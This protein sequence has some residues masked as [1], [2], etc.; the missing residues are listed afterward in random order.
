MF[1][2]FTHTSFFRAVAVAV[3]VAFVSLIPA[4]S[5]YAQ[6]L[7]Q[8][9]EPGQMV[10]TTG[11]FEPAL[12]AGLRVDMKDPFKFYFVMDKGEQVMAPDVESQEYQKLIKYFLASLTIAND[13]MWVN[14][15]PHEANRIIPDNFA[16]TSMGR[17]LLAQDYLLKQ[18]TASLIYP[19]DK[20]GRDF[21][22]KVYAKVYERY[23]T[24]EIPLDTFNK[25]WITADK[26]DIYQKNDTAL[27]LNSHLKVMLEQDFMA[28]EQNKEQ[29]GNVQ[30]SDIPE[31]NAARK[32][33]A[34]IVREII[35]PVIE[36]EVNDGE[37]FAQV[38]QVYSAMIMASWFKKTL[39][40]SLLGQIYTDKNKVSG[41][42]V[43]DP[44]AKEKIYQKY[45]E[46]YKAGV[47]N[48][49]KEEVD[50][51]THEMLP[52]KYF[53]GGLN[54]G[55]AANPD[56][57]TNFAQATEKM[58]Q[59]GGLKNVARKALLTVAL[60]AMG[61]MGSMGFTVQ[62]QAQTQPAVA[63]VVQIADTTSAVSKL[64]EGL[65]KLGV[66]VK[67]LTERKANVNRGI[68][69]TLQQ[70]IDALNS[71]IRDMEA[72]LQGL[73]PGSVS[74]EELQLAQKSYQK[75]IQAL[76]D[77]VARLENGSKGMA[78]GVKI[79]YDVQIN[80]TKGKIERLQ[81]LLKMLETPSVPTNVVE[82]SGDKVGPVA[83]N[84]V[85][86]PVVLDAE[87]LQA[88]EAVKKLGNEITEDMQ[89][90]NG[91]GAVTEG[92]KAA[93]K[94]LEQKPVL[95][96]AA[97]AEIAGLK[98]QVEER[99][100]TIQTLQNDRNSLN[101]ANADL[102]KKQADAEKSV[103]AVVQ[104]ESNL[105]HNIGLL[106]GG[107]F[108]GL[109]ASAGILKLDSVLEKRKKDLARAKA[110]EIKA[111]AALEEA[112]KNIQ[113]DKEALKKQELDVNNSVK[114]LE[115]EVVQAGV[116]SKVN[117]EIAALQEKI[118]A[119][120]KEV[121][122]AVAK[123]KRLNEEIAALGQM[124]GPER[125]LLDQVKRIEGLMKSKEGDLQ[126]KLNAVKSGI[127]QLKAV[128]EVQRTA[129]K[130]RELNASTI[131]K[132]DLPKARAA[133]AR[134]DQEMANLTAIEDLLGKDPLGNFLA[135]QELL[136]EV[137]LAVNNA[138]AMRKLLAEL[139]IAQG[140]RKQA[141]RAL[142]DASDQ[143]RRLKKMAATPGAVQQ[144]QDIT[145]QERN[146]RLGI[147]NDWLAKNE[148]V[149]TGD[150]MRLVGGMY[151]GVGEVYGPDSTIKSE[152]LR[153]KF[154]T[155]SREKQVAVLTELVNKI[156]GNDIFDAKEKADRVALLQKWLDD[157]PLQPAVEAPAKATAAPTAPATEKPSAIKQDQ[158][159]PV[160]I[161][162]ADRNAAEWAVFEGWDSVEKKL[163]GIV[164]SYGKYV[165]QFKTWPLVK[166]IAAI[167]ASI[168]E[169]ENEKNLTGEDEKDRLLRIERMNDWLAFVSAPAKQGEEAA[170]EVSED[171]VTTAGLALM[172][173]RYDQENNKLLSPAP[174]D[175]EYGKRVVLFNSWS[176]QKQ[177]AAVKKALDGFI[178]GGVL[179]N[180]QDEKDRL[181]LVAI[182]QKWLE[183]NENLG[184][185]NLSD[186]HLTINIK[187][188]GQ[189][190]PLPAQFQ[191]AA[192]RNIQGLSPVIR[193]IAPVTAAN[194]P[195][196][197]ELLQ[198][199][200]TP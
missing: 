111:K 167:K 195:V 105:S 90:E 61:A 66:R 77:T 70:D 104:E 103:Q 197:T 42:K 159:T 62:A 6:V 4:Q 82:A 145:D 108:L 55:K 188:D 93:L 44:K 69:D 190:M 59:H 172:K 149:A 11:H 164:G 99:N 73:A 47:F 14:L 64:K 56:V 126:D 116:A 27:L 63:P 125:E 198:M 87:H 113:A 96:S 166:Q 20:V 185:I 152:D 7:L 41:V 131:K 21:W 177:K 34:D 171:D 174:Q 12:M 136:K 180:P 184:G 31:A 72:L 35:V 133:L 8:M 158:G 191:D 129:A 115:T 29:F 135:A 51:M 161:S 53:S 52:R 54:P 151:F 46:A 9:P 110:V 15:S 92:T 169:L 100:A 178:N 144:K 187:V 74:P 141:R 37:N 86:A 80:K 23:G 196:L 123:I 81:K 18:F 193:E 109:L 68:Q 85:Q 13:D 19:E 194:M 30:A 137:Y 83:P 199:A 2:S 102:R 148:P 97:K 120:E 1:Q 175:A 142:Q 132:F 128:L 16:Q 117:P 50:P 75:D 154:N 89:V 146:D 10:R 107:V 65:V 94:N 114:K 127:E 84:E 38:R 5:G 3:I 168:D 58:P 186:K 183:K 26:A 98:R 124:S 163:I 176:V 24:T 118:T 43:D 121:A 157:N 182:M 147:I 79:E 76:M 33:A 143:L 78:I 32:I 189:G 48:Y 179:E 162:V 71:K 22:D 173:G 57:T 134:I 181:D 140:E 60:I 170:V 106:I 17:D 155:W 91:T 88:S 156:K 119:I 25:V 36:K 122:A 160:E 95:T 130:V 40:A 45:V 138:P 101:T 139:K 39:K 200:G 67:E 28:V 49:I 153:S 150:D 192:M 112:E 165:E